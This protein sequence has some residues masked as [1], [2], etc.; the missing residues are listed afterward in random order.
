MKYKTKRLWYRNFIASNI[1]SHIF[2]ALGVPSTPKVIFKDI[3][4]IHQSRQWIPKSQIRQNYI[5]L[6]NFININYYSKVEIN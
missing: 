1:F 2:I 5:N 4:Y 6:I 3:L